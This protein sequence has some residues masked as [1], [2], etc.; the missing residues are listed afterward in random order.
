MMP[1]VSLHRCAFDVAADPVGITKQ[2]FFYHDHRDQY[3]EGVRRWRMMR[4]E[5]FAYTLNG[6]TYCGSQDSGGDNHCR[7]W[8]GFPVSVGMGSIRRTGRNFQPAPDDKRA[9]NI[10]PGFN[11]IGDED[12]GV[13]EHATENLCDREN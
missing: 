13:T 12:I 4:Q 5:N 1:G 3:H 10:E 9:R 7:N 6:E 2:T 11:A 8:L